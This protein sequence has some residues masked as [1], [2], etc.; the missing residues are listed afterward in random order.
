M[1]YSVMLV[2]TNAACW[3]GQG[4]AGRG[5]AGQDT[6]QGRAGQGGAGRE[7]GSHQGLKLREKG[8]RQFVFYAPMLQSL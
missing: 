3:A 8:T 4:R 6:G 1:E 2:K 7:H 5:R